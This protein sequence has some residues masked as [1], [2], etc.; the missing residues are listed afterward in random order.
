MS[1]YLKSILIVESLMS[2]EALILKSR[3]GKLVYFYHCATLFSS[4]QICLSFE[5]ACF[6]FEPAYFSLSV[7]QGSS[8]IIFSSLFICSSYFPSIFVSLFSVD[9]LCTSGFHFRYLLSFLSTEP[10][11][12]IFF[13]FVLF[14]FL[15]ELVESPISMYPLVAIFECF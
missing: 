8:S 9:L 5:C 6:S 12:Q 7:G 4:L 3:F 14:A 2:I 10:G 15:C 11:I 13:L 1:P